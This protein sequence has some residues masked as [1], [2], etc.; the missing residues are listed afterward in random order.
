MLSGDLPLLLCLAAAVAVLAVLNGSLALG[1][2]R[3]ARRHRRCRAALDGVRADRDQL[4]LKVAALGAKDG[5]VVVFPGR[6]FDPRKDK[7]R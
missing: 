7:L 3:L 1:Y 5:R 4:Q 6:P 2:A